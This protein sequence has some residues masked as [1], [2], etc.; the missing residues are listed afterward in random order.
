MARRAYSR[1]GH[2]CYHPQLEIVTMRK[3]FGG[4]VV[5]ALALSLTTAAHA[6]RRA[7]S[8]PMGGAKHEHGVPAGRGRRLAQALRKR[9]L[10]IQ[11]WLDLGLVQQRARTVLR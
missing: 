5:A 3:L 6:Q 7:A 4:M 2:R 9:R 11:G 1:A 8:A 10:A